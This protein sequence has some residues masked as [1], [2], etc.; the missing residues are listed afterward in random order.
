MDFQN[1]P[2]ELKVDLIYVLNLVNQIEVIYENRMIF[3]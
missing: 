3:S 1:S 2:S